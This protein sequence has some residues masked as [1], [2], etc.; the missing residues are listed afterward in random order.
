MAT[1]LLAALEDADDIAE[2]TLLIGQALGLLMKTHDAGAGDALIGL[3]D[4]AAR[5]NVGLPEAA[6]RTIAELPPPPR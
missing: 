5:D 4:R 3:E 1:H 2:A 6:R